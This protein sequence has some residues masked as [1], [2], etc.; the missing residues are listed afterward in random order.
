MGIGVPPLL[1]MLSAIGSLTVVV[2]KLAPECPHSLWLRPGGG[3][4]LNLAQR[5]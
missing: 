2:T 1:R 5:G 3:A 4:A